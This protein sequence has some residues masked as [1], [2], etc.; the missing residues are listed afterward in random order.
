MG[1]IDYLVRFLCAKLDVSRVDVSVTYSAHHEHDRV[2]MTRWC[3]SFCFVTGRGDR[4]PV[5][6]DAA[7]VD[8]NVIRLVGV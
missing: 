3:G 7:S 1:L 6:C 5:F 4:V 8:T 2:I